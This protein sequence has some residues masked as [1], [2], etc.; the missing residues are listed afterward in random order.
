MTDIV[1]ATANARFSHA[2]LALRCLKADLGCLESQAA[3]VEFTID[4]RPADI[5]EKLLSHEPLILGLGVYIWNVSLLEDA[6]SII[7][8]IRPDLPVVVGGPEVSFE[9]DR[10][11]IARLADFIIK[12]EGEVAFKELCE[13]LLAGKKPENK[14]VDPCFCDLGSLSMPYRLYDDSD[15]EHRV[16]YVE[17]SRGCPFGCE[18]CLSSLD[19]RVRKFPEDRLVEQ[20]GELW[21]R[22]ARR[23]KFTDRALHLAVTEKIAGFFLKRAEHG[24]FVHFELIPDHLPKN[25]FDVLKRFPKGAL[26]LE[27]GM[28]TLNPSVASDIGR[29]QNVDKALKNLKRLLNETN[30]HLHTDLVIGLPG[31][32]IES[33]ADG[34]DALMAIGPQE[35]QVGIL[36]RLRGAP[37]SRH[38]D[39]WKMI[40][41][42]RPPYDIL[43]NRLL[44]F[45]TLQRLKR[46]SR[47]FDLLHNSGNFKS[48]VT[49]VWGSDSPFWSFLK[50]SD[51]IYART[52]RTNAIALNRLAE[53]LFN[54]LVLKRAVDKAMAANALFDDYVRAG[55]K[56]LPGQVLAHVTSRTMPNLEKKHT[57]S[58]PRQRRHA[59]S[60][61]TRTQTKRLGTKGSS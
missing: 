60:A 35:I 9:I 7:K 24:L 59:A 30:A 31:E 44:S 6:V 33:F 51:W 10:Q 47:Y 15:I 50:L 39:E 4:D 11:R 49:L 5:A 38:D 22:G 21:R 57:T 1:L 56:N 43:Q 26:Q 54:Y 42:E 28:Q 37:I 25:L 34:F 40:Y 53:H 16:L 17:A 20:L 14:V 23:F 18:F 58:P 2:S 12:G 52:G 32:T 46:F 36:K 61:D 55:R 48:S 45:S 41:N 19:R 8:K 29:R 27:A 3:I 13:S